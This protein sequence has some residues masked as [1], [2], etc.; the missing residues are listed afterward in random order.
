MSAR[1]ASRLEQF[2]FTDV[3]EYVGGKE[4]WLASGL[5]F[6]SE[7]GTERPPV[8]TLARE[9]WPTCEL[10]DRAGDVL[11]QLSDE[12]PFAVVVGERR[13]VLG[14]LLRRRAEESPDTTVE[15]VLVEGPTTVRAS[16]EP[17][18][19]GQRMEQAGTH[20]VLVTSK[21]GRLIGVLVTDDLVEALDRAAAEHEGH[22]AHS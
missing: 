7:H 2:G 9:D 5:A 19:L 4:D 16:E 14:K 1:A 6:E 3:V 11:E 21:E 10:E 18:R 22:H 13:T 17:A 12:D 20:S 8:A 15:D